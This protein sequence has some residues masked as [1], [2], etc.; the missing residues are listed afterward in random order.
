M[1]ALI[2][3]TVFFGEYQD[4]LM[5]EGILVEADSTIYRVKYDII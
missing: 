1:I 5:S 2:N 4:A 3:N